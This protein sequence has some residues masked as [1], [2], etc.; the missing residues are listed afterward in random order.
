M[1]TQRSSALLA[2]VLVVAGLAGATPSPARAHGLYG[3]V[4]VTGWAID[5]L[6]PGELRDMLA[7]PEVRAAALMGAAFPDTGYA[8]IDEELQPRARIYGETAHWEPFVQS[9]VE[10]VRERYAPPYDTHE[11]HLV[12]AFLLGVASH[13]LQ[14]E[15]FDST[16]LHECEQRDGAGQ[17]ATDPGTDGFLVA[18]GYQWMYPGDFV[19]WEDLLVLYQPVDPSIDREVIEDGI[20]VVKSAYLN[21]RVGLRVARAN[22]DR[23]RDEIPWAAAHYVDPAVAGSLRAE[24]EPTAAHMQA[25]WERLHGREREEDLVVHAWPDPPRRLREGESES[26]ASWVTLVLGRGIEQGSATGTFTDADGVAHPFELAYTR[27]GGT[28]RLV[29]F[30]PRADLAPG[31]FYEVTLQPGARLVDGTTT[32]LAHS[33]RFQVECDDAE[34][35]PPVEVEDP[36]IDPPPPPPPMDAGPPDA[37]TTPVARGGGGCTVGAPRGSAPWLVALAL[38]ALVARRRVRCAG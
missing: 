5:H 21:E 12:I 38:I 4:H 17:D 8:V 37:G 10:H 26:V 6:P 15:L 9:F 24:V 22:A 7:D 30:Q 16:F 19:P 3:H 31:A 32:A 34:L 18:D 20:R 29:R 35:C 25:L 13:G 14:D 1:R 23:Y 33:H 2:L 11:E 36:S 27:W 28:S